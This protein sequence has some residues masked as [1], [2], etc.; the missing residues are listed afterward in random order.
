MGDPA[1]SVFYNVTIDGFIPLGFWTK[2]DGLGMEYEVFEYREG[3]VNGYMH[4]LV[5][6]VKFTN[7]RLS[8]PVDTTSPA[9]MMWLGSNQM[10]VVPQTM[11]ITAMTAS[12]EA[13]TTWNLVGAVPVKWTG[14]SLDVLSNNLATET[15]EVAYQEISLIGGLASALTGAI[16]G[17]ISGSVSASVSF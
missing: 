10:M 6:P 5:G 9:L 16:G 14:P 11:A 4:K 2:V 15:L 17:A 8:R 13:I 1:I 3:G 7:L 12:G